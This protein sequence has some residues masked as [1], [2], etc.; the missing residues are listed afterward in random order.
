[1]PNYPSKDPLHIAPWIL[2]ASAALLSPEGRAPAP[3]TRLG[4]VAFEISCKPDVKPDFNRGVGFLHSFWYEA[5]KE[6]FAKVTA[7]DPGCAMAYWGEAMTGF[8]QVNGWPDA[9]AVADA[10][11]ALASADTASERTPREAAWIQTLHVFYD[12]FRREDARAHAR[13]YADAMAALAAAYPQ[14]LEAQVFY[15]LAL[16]ASDPRDDVALVNARKAYAILDPLFAQHPDHPGIAHY[17]IHACDNPQMAQQGLAAA[18]RYA[19]IAPASPHALHMPGHIFARLGLWPDDVQSNLASRAA[20][21]HPD[22]MRVGAENRLHAMEFLEYAYLQMG[23]YAEAQAIVTDARTVR[24]ADVDPRYPRYYAIVEARFPSMYAV[25]TQD[26]PMA[27]GLEPVPGG[28]AYSQALTL[29]ARVTA[30]AHRHDARAADQALRVIEGLA[31]QDAQSPAGSL[32]H[33]LPDEIRAW[34]AFTRGDLAHARALLQP[35]AERQDHVGKGEVERPAREMLADMLLLHG[36][37]RQALEEYQAALSS[38]PNR[39]NALLGAGE[40]AERLGQRALAKDYYLRLLANCAAAN[41]AAK[42]LLA[43]AS[44]VV[45]AGVRR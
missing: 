8:P 36:D 34:A 22:G 20:A 32:G 17:I 5:A 11:H 7:A 41:G 1:L 37:A 10:E 25:E 27:A 44:M 38:D 12:G 23:K 4:S 29:L 45:E 14:D 13:A 39:L 24:A 6:T 19:S 42:E 31:R 33:T 16:L 35:L 26:W 30:A 18:R 15:A 40:A 3:A 2:A 9:A 28:D 43:H 21:E